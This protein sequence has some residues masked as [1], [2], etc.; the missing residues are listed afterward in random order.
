MR[1]GNRLELDH[2]AS[3]PADAAIV[4]PPLQGPWIEGLPNDDHGFIPVDRHGRVAGA[5]GV[6]A[7]GDATAFPIK[8]G[9]LATQQADAAPRA[10]AADLGLRATARR[11]GPCCAGC[12]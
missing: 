6:Y 9:G 2:G 5:P 11:S 1:R 7:A 10:I 4:L 8:Q 12:S 3:V